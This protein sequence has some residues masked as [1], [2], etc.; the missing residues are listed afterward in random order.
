MRQVTLEI[1]VTRTL[2]IVYELKQM[3]WVM[4]KDFDFAHHKPE[5]DDFG[6]DFNF[7]RRTV[8]T[9]YN[10]SNASYF[11]LKWG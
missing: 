8:F 11:T 7:P 9:F 3:G 10:D 4:G 1:N 5:Y 6:H 2:E